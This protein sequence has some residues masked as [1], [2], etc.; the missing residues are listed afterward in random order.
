[1]RRIEPLILKAHDLVGN[2]ILQ[3]SALDGSQYTAVPGSRASL[4]A[5]SSVVSSVSLAGT[6][7]AHALA[8]SPLDGASFGEPADDEDGIR[9]ARHAHALPVMADHLH[10]ATQQLELCATA[11]RYVASGFDRDLAST[12]QNTQPTPPQKVS[13]TQQHALTALATGGARLRAANNYATPRV[14]V[15][16]GSRVGLATF[17]SLARRGLIH[18]DTSAPLYQGQNVSVTAQGHRALAHCRIT[19]TLPS[20]AVPAPPTAASTLGARR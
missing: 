15:P 5:L 10:N 19:A 3:L 18:V 16:D 14:Y 20:A 1:M 8:A 7:L 12:A 2:S 17:A 13:P 6:D 4:D 9:Q 11:C